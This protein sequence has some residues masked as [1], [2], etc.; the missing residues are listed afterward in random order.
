MAKRRVPTRRPPKAHEA[1]REA[2]AIGPVAIDDA[3][4][5]AQLRALA[6]LYA[7]VA[8]AQVR[9]TS[10]S[11]EAKTAKK[12]LEAATSAL[13]EKVRAVTHPQALPLFDPDHR[14]ADLED[15]LDAEQR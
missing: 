7:A 1:T 3:T 9:L 10:K 11:E 12:R 8:E 2:S 14:E 15:M 4:A 5:G 13:L 6:N